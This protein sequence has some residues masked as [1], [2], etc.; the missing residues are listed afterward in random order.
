M[1]RYDHIAICNDYD[2]WS[3][4]DENATGEWIKYTDFEEYRLSLS[5]YNDKLE[6]RTLKAE[7]E[8]NEAVKENNKKAFDMLSIL[9]VTKERAIT[10]SNGIEVLSTRYRKDRAG[11]EYNIQQAVKAEKEKRIGTRN[12]LIDLYNFY[13]TRL[14]DFNCVLKKGEADL[15]YKVEKFI[16]ARS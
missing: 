2:E 4:M 11:Y 5:D 16:R 12:V 6:E 14:D 10:V 7:A 13:A 3:S 8:L 1:K 15:I 9:G